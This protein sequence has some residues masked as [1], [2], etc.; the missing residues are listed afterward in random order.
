MQLVPSAV[1]SV[2]FHP[3]V[4]QRLPFVFGDEH[5]KHRAPHF[6][7]RGQVDSSVSRFGAFETFT[8]QW[9][10]N[11]L[12]HELLVHFSAHISAYPRF[13]TAFVKSSCGRGV[14]H[15][16]VQAWRVGVSGFPVFGAFVYRLLSR[17]VARHQCNEAHR[18]QSFHT[19]S[20]GV[21]SSE[22]TNG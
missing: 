3:K 4:Q 14:H 6:V 15:F 20:F 8:D 12:V 16:S 11:V 7:L 2:V 17:G 18:F 10:E 9:S 1:Q 5:V 21:H 13:T 19:S 22:V